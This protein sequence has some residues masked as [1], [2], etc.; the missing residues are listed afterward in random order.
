MKFEYYV[1]YLGEDRRH[2]RWITEHFI[3]VDSEEITNKKK[4]IQQKIEDK[5]KADEKLKEQQA[6]YNDE[7]HG[8]SERQVQEF[9]ANSK[10]KTVESIHFGQNWLETWYFTPVPKEFHC[11]CLYICEFCLFFFVTKEEF[12]RHTQRCTWTH[13]PGTEIYR[14]GDISFFEIDGI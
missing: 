12:K 3:R 9:M 13:P 2:D 11:K 14:D 10:F 5:K 6:F 4:K 7:N 8:M 1:H